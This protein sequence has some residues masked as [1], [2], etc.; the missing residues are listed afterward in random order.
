M[1][2]KCFRC[3]KRPSEIEEYV[4]EAEAEGITPEQYV[5]ENEGTYN[6]SNGHFACTDCYLRMGAPSSPRGWKAP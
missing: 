1:D 4:I 3:N 5:R 2:C 6:R